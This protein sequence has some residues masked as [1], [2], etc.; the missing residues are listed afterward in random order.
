MNELHELRKKSNAYVANMHQNIELA[1]IPFEHFLI[2][3]Q[4]SQWRDKQIDAQGNSLPLYSEHWKAIKGI[5]NYN[6]YDTGSFQNNVVFSM[7][8]P[9]YSFSSTDKKKTI[10]EERIKN[11]GGGNIWGIAPLN[12]EAAKAITS[13]AIGINYKR[14]LGL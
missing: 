14:A 1:I 11:K 4:T 9:N 13:K 6:L 10:I 3:F 8:Y 12:Q 7:K 5:S 2:E